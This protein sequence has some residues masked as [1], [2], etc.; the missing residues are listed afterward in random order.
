MWV[1]ILNAY[2]T[3]IVHFIDY[4]IRVYT[5]NAKN[6]YYNLFV[7]YYSSINKGTYNLCSFGEQS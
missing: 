6:L 7:Q 3:H 5:L 4:L 2:I 1:N